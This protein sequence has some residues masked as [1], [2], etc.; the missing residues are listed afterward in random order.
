MRCQCKKFQSIITGAQTCRTFCRAMEAWCP[1]LAYRPA[2]PCLATSCV[3]P[4]RSCFLEHV[5]TAMHV[6]HRTSKQ[7]SQA[8][9]RPIH[10]SSTSQL[11]LDTNTHTHTG[12]QL[13][14]IKLVHTF[15]FGEAETLGCTTMWSTMSRRTKWFTDT[16]E[17]RFFKLTL[18]WSAATPNYMIACKVGKF[19]LASFMLKM[20]VRPSWNDGW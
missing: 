4:T 1:L 10:T 17:G 8:W 16:L 11:Q 2:V 6:L 18:C 13:V 12:N 3:C 15:V 7:S 19:L 5:E 9:A 20:K 14:Q